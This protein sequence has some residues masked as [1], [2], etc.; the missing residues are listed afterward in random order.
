MSRILPCR[1]SPAMVVALLALFVALGG[2]AYAAISLP[3]NSV[4]TKQ[5]KK[6]AVTS[7]KVRDASLLK[8][9]FASGQLPQGQQGPPGQAGANGATNVVARDSA[10]KTVAAGA[11]D[12]DAVACATGEKG[13]GG[14]VVVLNNAGTDVINTVPVTESESTV[15][16]GGHPDGWSGGISNTSASPVKLVVEAIC[17]AP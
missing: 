8:T 3:K 5:L 10:P 4:G 15:D 13:T 6:N 17:A 9:D 11:N 1:P 16:A 7:G 14:G 2:G 12:F